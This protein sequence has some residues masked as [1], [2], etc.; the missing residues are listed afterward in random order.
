MR[1]VGGTDKIMRIVIGLAMISLIFI[2]PQSLWGLLGII[3]LATGL[4][5]FCPVYPL[6]GISTAEKKDESQKHA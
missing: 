6:L 5:N 2:G 4:I 1:N 3:P